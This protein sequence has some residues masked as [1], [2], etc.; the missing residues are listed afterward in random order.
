MLSAGTKLGPY[1]ITTAI[2]AGGMGE[3]YRARDSKLGRDVAIKVL[4]EAFAR[5]PDRMARF[6]REAKVLA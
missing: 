4:P 3:V 5:D 2:G 6:Q 1:E